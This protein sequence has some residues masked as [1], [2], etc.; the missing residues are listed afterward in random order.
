MDKIKIK[1]AGS[2]GGHNGL[3]SI[4]EILGSS[5]YARLRFGIGNDFPKGRQVE[6]VLGKW[7]KKEEPVVATKIE[8][9]AD[10]IQLFVLTDLQHAM[11]AVNNLVF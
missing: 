10:A 9:S 5:N 8:K 7:A 6:H 3:K 4:Q 11:N 1:P 2:D